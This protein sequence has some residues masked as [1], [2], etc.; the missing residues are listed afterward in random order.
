MGSASNTNIVNQHWVS[1][2]N[3][4]AIIWLVLLCSVKSGSV[5]NIGRCIS[6][7]PLCQS[8]L[9]SN[10]FTRCGSFIGCNLPGSPFLDSQLRQTPALL[11]A[12]LVTSSNAQMVHY[13]SS[14]NTSVPVWLQKAKEALCTYVV[15]EWLQRLKK[16]KELQRSLG[17]K[18]RWRGQ[19]VRGQSWR[20]TSWRC[21][22]VVK[23]QKWGV[24]SWR[25]KRQDQI[26]VN[27]W[28]CQVQTR[29]L[30]W[31]DR[32]QL[33]QITPQTRP[34]WNSWDRSF[35]L[36]MPWILLGGQM[37]GWK[38]HRITVFGACLCTGFIWGN[39]LFPRL[40]MPV[41]AFLV[42]TLIYICTHLL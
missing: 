27:V 20:G 2:G 22:A 16:P 12:S 31:M 10:K 13:R 33:E 28:E 4:L 42:M 25:S 11:F 41:L 35:L 19:G 6:V 38:G 34:S 5:R 8:L 36:L 21:C 37:T 17:N 32:Q 30:G 18:S 24:G 1:S 26:Q 15:T 40:D 3:S 7:F 9:S 14:S 29:V 39:H 23:L